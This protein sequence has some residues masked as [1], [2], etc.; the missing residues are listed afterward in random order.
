[1]NAPGYGYRAPRRRKAIAALRAIALSGLVVLF[2]PSGHAAA[3]F[4]GDFAIEPHF[5][6]EENFLDWKAYQNP[7]S[8]RYAWYTT[9]NG[10]SG[11]VGSLSQKRFLFAQEI[12]LDVDVGRHGTFSYFQSEDS[13][14]RP[15]P[16]FQQV[17]FR[18]GE[19]IY[20]S[21]LGF[22]A[23]DKRL[24]EVG[25]AVGYGRRYEWE[26]VRYS[27]LDQGRYYNEKNP[28]DN[29][30]QQTPT[31]D[32]I[33]LRRFFNERV[34]VQ[35]DIKWERKARF[36]EF[37][38]EM[39]RRYEGLEADITVDWWR[40]ETQGLPGERLIGA[41]WSIDREKR[42][43]RPALPSADL[44]DQRQSLELSQLDI[45][46]GTI[47]AETDFLTLG[48]LDSR[49]RNRIRSSF[50]EAGFRNDL[51]TSQGYAVWEHDRREWLSWIFTLQA[52]PA[53]FSIREGTDETKAE[54][55]ESLQIKAGVG[56][57][58]TE[59]DHYRFFF[60]T[61]WD[62]DLITIRQWD[63]GNVQ[64]HLYF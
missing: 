47:L 5:L 28:D 35:V 32:R 29:R 61:T 6:E 37:D 24:I 18:L 54:S 62:F 15:D 59:A 22:P 1:M 27:H 3:Q 44:P 25:F 10:F 41:T 12:K 46:F 30:Y 36:E 45:Y 52:G 31:L 42:K 33:E 63:G 40:G 8:W 48:Y 56:V 23:H 39:Q 53:D 38:P 4:N 20:G 50:E 7:T 16:I 57:V 58:L 9:R 55:K 64:I 49:F 19:R 2:W 14:F 51:D 43:Q 26:Y 60:N 11:T 17:E 34:F 21:I 13:F